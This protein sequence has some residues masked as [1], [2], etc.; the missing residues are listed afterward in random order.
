MPIG[1]IN[2][3][4]KYQTVTSKHGYNQVFAED[5]MSAM[6]KEEH[7]MSVKSIFPRIGLVRKS[8]D[9]IEELK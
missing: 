2:S 9:I 8:K 6:V 3:N 7:E 5:A 1:G 4:G